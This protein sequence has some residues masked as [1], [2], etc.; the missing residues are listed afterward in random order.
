M[1]SRENELI[2]TSSGRRRGRP[3]KDKT[4]CSVAGCEKTSTRN[5]DGA[6]VCDTH[7]MQIYRQQPGL[8][9]VRG[10]DGVVRLGKKRNRRWCRSH[11]DRYL[12]DAPK[13]RDA[14]LA[15]LAQRIAFDNI[16]DINCWMVDGDLGRP[17]IEVDGLRWVAVRFLWTAF[18]GSHRGGLQLHHVCGN[19][20]C[21]NPS[22]CW[23][24]TRKFNDEIED[25]LDEYRGEDFVSRFAPITAEFDEWCRAN[26]L[27]HG[28]TT[29]IDSGA[30]RFVEAPVTR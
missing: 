28:M 1:E 15:E 23:P 13:R 9:S 12:S 16:G 24:M 17:T 8:C 19:G 27:D 11:E 30:R 21:V 4:P 7:R 25:H 29:E 18:Y 10:C 14:A 5:V 26:G 20:W 6:R 2:G 22:H 3:R